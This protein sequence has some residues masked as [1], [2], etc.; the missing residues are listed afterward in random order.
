M[1]LLSHIY[2]ARSEALW[3]EPA[4]LSWFEAQ[5]T[6]KFSTLN[7]SEAQSLRADALA[8]IQTPRDPVDAEINVPLFI[9]RH[10]VC[11]ESTSWLGFL[12]PQIRAKT[13]HAYDPLPPYTAVSAY[14]GNYFNAVRAVRRPGQRGGSEQVPDTEGFV[15]QLLRAVHQDPGNWRNQVT[16]TFRE[17]LG[18]R[19][20][21]D[22]P[23][24]DRQEML[25]QVRDWHL[26]QVTS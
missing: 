12:P 16:E 15:R 6:S 1:H 11:S 21:A 4:T 22:L 14:D 20:V 23:E 2:V 8:M 9:C 24:V 7:T 25:Q 18:W 13:V 26:R 19:G 17:M 10:I 3:K 5:V